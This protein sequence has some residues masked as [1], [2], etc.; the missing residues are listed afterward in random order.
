MTWADNDYGYKKEIIIDK[1]K[2]AGDETDYPILLLFTDGDLADTDNSGYVQSSNGY[3]IVFY[4]STETT[5]LEHEIQSYS[6]T[7]GAIIFWVCVK[8]LSSTSNTSIYMYFGKSGVGSDPSSTSTWDSDYIA[9]YHMNGLSDSTS[10]GKTLTNHGADLS[11][12]GKIGDCYE[13]VDANDDHMTN[14]A[15]GDIST[16]TTMTLEMWA[17]PDAEWGA[18]DGNMAGIMIGTNWYDDH[19]T[20]NWANVH[21]FYSV[22]SHNASN[23]NYWRSSDSYPDDG[24]W[25]Y[26]TGTHTADD[27]H[28]FVNGQIDEVSDYTQ[29]TINWSNMDDD[30]LDIGFCES[31]SYPDGHIDEIRISKSVRGDNWIVTTYNTQNAPGTFLEVQTLET[32]PS[33]GVTIKAVRIIRRG[34]PLKIVKSVS[35]YVKINT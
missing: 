11:N 31:L 15:I 24:S 7:D 28:M 25:Y 8:S 17:N 16:F 13:F 34:V 6:N 2:V 10:N 22:M 1:D 29:G 21:K 3:D 30:S 9:V 12:D 20:L 4:E 35:K 32:K 33:T 18:D 26:A 27:T 19:I 5:Q 23:R 14:A